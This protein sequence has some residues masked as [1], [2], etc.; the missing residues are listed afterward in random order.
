MT[1]KPLAIMFLLSHLFL[2]AYAYEMDGYD[3]KYVR[4]VNSDNKSHV[5]VKLYNRKEILVY[6]KNPKF[7]KETSFSTGQENNLFYIILLCNAPTKSD[8]M[9]FIIVDRLTGKYGYYEKL[10]AFNSKIKVGFF[11]KN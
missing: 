8:D 10:L 2:T 9:C 6:E 1:R 3:G 11:I 5:Y 7:S 4:I